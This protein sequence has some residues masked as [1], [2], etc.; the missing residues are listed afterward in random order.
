MSQAINLVKAS[1]AS[2]AAADLTAHGS[3][4]A[5]GDYFVNDGQTFLMVKNG[6]ASDH[7]VT[8]AFGTAPSAQVDGQTPSNVTHNVTAG[9]TVLLGP[10]PT[11]AYNDGSGFGQLSYSATTSMTI[12]AVQCPTS[13]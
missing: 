6:D 10:W 1:R 3:S 11:G 9:H 7:T 2:P 8:V 5:S 4:C 13:G 12:M